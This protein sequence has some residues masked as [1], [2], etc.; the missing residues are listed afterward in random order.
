MIGICCGL[1]SL[2]RDMDLGRPFVYQLLRSRS[3][4]ATIMSSRKKKSVQFEHATTSIM[5][6][7]S[8]ER[9]NC[10]VL[11][12]YREYVRTFGSEPQSTNPRITLSAPAALSLSFPSLPDKARADTPTRRPSMRSRSSA[13]FMAEVVVV[14]DRICSRTAAVVGCSRCYR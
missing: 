7:W 9:Q 11:R 12:K 6:S 3:P 10:Q 4:E 14:T 13:L 8:C 1:R 2:Q 5:S